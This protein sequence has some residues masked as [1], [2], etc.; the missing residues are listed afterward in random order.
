MGL[1]PRPVSVAAFGRAHVT[2]GHE[3]L[4]WSGTYGAPSA[5]VAEPT[6]RLAASAGHAGLSDALRTVEPL[7]RW[8]V[9]AALPVIRFMTRVPARAMA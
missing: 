9:T 2:V 1:R 7:P 5:S 8:E 6:D 3:I 4:Q